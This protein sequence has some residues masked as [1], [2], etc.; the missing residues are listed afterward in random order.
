MD[1]RRMVLYGVWV[2]FLPWVVYLLYF[3]GSNLLHLWKGGTDSE[4]VL[5]VG[6][7]FGLGL[8]AFSA[9]MLWIATKVYSRREASTSADKSMANGM[10]RGDC[11]HSE[12][13]KGAGKTF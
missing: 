13:R 3:L 5:I 8:L 1:A 10:T 12:S 7:V 11:G 4:G 9:W 2:I 6:V